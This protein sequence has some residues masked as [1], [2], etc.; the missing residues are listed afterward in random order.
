MKLHKALFVPTICRNLILAT[1]GNERVKKQL[2]ILK[3]T[4]ISK[5][6]FDKEL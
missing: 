4:V 6:T 5:E 2:K 1:C 3:T